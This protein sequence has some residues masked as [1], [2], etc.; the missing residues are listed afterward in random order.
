MT[1]R[2]MYRKGKLS[3]YR[4]QRLEAIGFVWY[5]QDHSWNEMFQRLVRYKEVNGDCNVPSG[6]K[7][8]PQLGSWVVM[9]YLLFRIVWRQSRRYLTTHFL[10][11]CQVKSVFGHFTALPVIRYTQNVPTIFPLF[12]TFHGDTVVLAL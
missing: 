6:W 7:E 8:D 11:R 12:D 10:A 3:Q 1:Q 2:Q 4:V 9:I 5:R